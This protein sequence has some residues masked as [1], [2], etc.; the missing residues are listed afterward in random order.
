MNELLTQYA[1]QLNDSGAFVR[2]AAR[3]ESDREM[4]DGDEI[5]SF[6]GERF[7]TLD[8]IFSAYEAKE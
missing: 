8:R 1:Q 4:A 7:F 6:A 3:W 5:Y 2:N